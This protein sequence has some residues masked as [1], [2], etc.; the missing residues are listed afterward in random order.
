MKP[1]KTTKRGASKADSKS[2]AGR[3][4]QVRFGPKHRDLLEELCKATP[5]QPECTPQHKVQWLI[6]RAH[7]AA[8]GDSK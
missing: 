4:M 8:F 5:E 3:F 2:T 7:E 6:E 1:T